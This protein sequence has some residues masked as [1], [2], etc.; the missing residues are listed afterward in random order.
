MNLKAIIPFIALFACCAP[1]CSKKSAS[2][3]STVASR[4]TAVAIIPASGS[5]NTPDTIV[6]TGFS[7]GDSVWYN[8]VA[9]A[10]QYVSADTLIVEVPLGAGTGPVTISGDGSMVIGPTFDYLLTVVVS[11]LAGGNVNPGY[12]D[13]QGSAAAFDLP[14]GVV[15]DGQGNL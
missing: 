6:G 11:T 8:K 3:P 2:P 1:G 5:Y 15:L 10:V 9:A 13:G 4:L 7:T 14:I 12:K